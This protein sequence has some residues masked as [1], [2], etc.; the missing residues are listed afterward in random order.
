M[1]LAIPAPAAALGF[2]G[3]V[4]FAGLAVLA[5]AAP[6]DITVRAAGLQAGYGA[7][8]LT[9]LG[10]VHWGVALRDAPE[11]TWPRLGWSVTPSL[12]GWAAL[13]LAPATALVVLIAALAIAFA[14][15]RRSLD[16]DRTPPWYLRLRLALTAGAIASLVVTLLALR[17][18]GAA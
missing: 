13:Q 14:I 12:I 16:D 8:I 1:A 5:A 7:V 18:H 4:P 15:D 17:L 9:F 2:A 10:A 11:V 6:P 3:L